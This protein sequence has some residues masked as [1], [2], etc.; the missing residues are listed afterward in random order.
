MAIEFA[1]TWDYRCPFAHIAHDHVLTALKA[2]ADWDVRFLPFSLDQ[3]HVAEGDRPVWEAPDRYPGLLANM[4]GIVVRDR[5]AEHFYDVHEALFAARHDSARDTR[6][7]DVV[8]AILTEAGMD[9]AAVLA[10]VDDGW[11]LDT[12]HKEHDA[13]ASNHDV[14][15]VPTFIVGNQA[16]FVRLLERPGGDVALATSTIERIVDLLQ[17][18]P[19]LNE[20][21]HTSLAQ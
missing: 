17:G 14:W 19:S 2:G 18:W 10:E 6:R 13:A 9:A 20:F 5:W 4:A 16:A 12:F 1:V 15:G 8:A 3:G 21:K 7:R 11:P